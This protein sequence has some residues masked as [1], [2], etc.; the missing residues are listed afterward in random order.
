MLVSDCDAKIWIVL[1]K[2]SFPYICLFS[3]RTRKTVLITHDLRSVMASSD[4][5]EL[6]GDVQ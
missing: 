3:P 6:M 4:T 1:R 5:M 2:A